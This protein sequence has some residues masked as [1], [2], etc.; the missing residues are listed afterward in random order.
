[1]RT[2][3]KPEPD[4]VRLVNE[5]EA[6]G[7]DT[8]KTEDFGEAG[9]ARD[10]SR[11]AD[12]CEKTARPGS[13]IAKDVSDAVVVKFQ[14]ERIQNESGNESGDA[15]EKPFHARCRSCVPHT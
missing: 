13:E 14:G 2:N 12:D 7:V 9:N 11:D 4:D 15:Q 3:A 6:V 8:D 5:I 1:M 10:Q